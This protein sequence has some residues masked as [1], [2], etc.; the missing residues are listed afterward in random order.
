M[1]FLRLLCDREEHGGAVDFVFTFVNHPWKFQLNKRTKLILWNVPFSG[2][3]LLPLTWWEKGGANLFVLTFSCKTLDHSNDFTHDVD[4]LFFAND[5][6]LAWIV[7]DHRTHSIVKLEHP[8]FLTE[9]LRVELD[10]LGVQN[11][12]AVVKQRQT[13]LSD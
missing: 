11:L 12:A 9:L 4:E 1:L 10:H 5:L 7:V 3:H 6:K 2:R 8:L 13:G